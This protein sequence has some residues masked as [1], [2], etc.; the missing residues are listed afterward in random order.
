MYLIASRLLCDRQS[1]VVRYATLLLMLYMV[2]EHFAPEKMNAMA[3]RFR[4]HGRLL[5]D[6]VVYKMS[7]IDEPGTR[8]YQVMEAED[9]ARLDQWI[10]RWNDLVDF[11]VVPVMTSTEFWEQRANPQSDGGEAHR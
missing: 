4:Q 11:E 7:W 6:G 9:R 5:P 1:L 8:C 10:A 2:I 3:D